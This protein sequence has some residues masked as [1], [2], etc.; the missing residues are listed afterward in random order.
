MRGEDP[1]P[2]FVIMLQDSLVGRYGGIIVARGREQSDA[3]GVRGVSALGGG[4]FLSE[5]VFSVSK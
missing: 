3:L 2:F 5:N 1:S 4:S